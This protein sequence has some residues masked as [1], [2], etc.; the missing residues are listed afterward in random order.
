V[1]LLVCGA[2]LVGLGAREYLA[3][4]WGQ[5]EAREEW[6][7]A[8]PVAVPPPDFGAAFARMSIPRLGSQ[9]FVFEGLNNNNLR[10]GPVHL[11]GTAEPGAGGNCVIAAHRDTHFRALKD[12]RA[13]DEISVETRAGKFTYTVSKIFIVK[14]TDTRALKPTTAGVMNLITCYPFYYVGRAPKRFVVEAHL[15]NPS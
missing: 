12:I 3:S 9:W 6:R 4:I 10:R 2:T 11:R 8:P 7:P 15:R 14:P 1:L 5:K 13:G